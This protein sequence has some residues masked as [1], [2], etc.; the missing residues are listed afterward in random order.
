MSKHNPEHSWIQNLK[1]F[2][3]RTIEQLNRLLLREHAKP[4]PQNY[5]ELWKLEAQFSKEQ[6]PERLQAR[7]LVATY[8]AGKG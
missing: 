6:D 8:K 1:S 3:Q 5:P 4:T 7:Q 2:L